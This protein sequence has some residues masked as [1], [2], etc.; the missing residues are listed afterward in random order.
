MR[1]LKVD[2]FRSISDIFQVEEG[3]FGD[4]VDVI[5]QS[6]MGVKNDTKVEVV[7]LRQLHG[8]LLHYQSFS[9]YITKIK[10]I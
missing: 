4:V 6:E 9:E 3:E 8:H 7:G 5:C 10:A 2:K 1:D